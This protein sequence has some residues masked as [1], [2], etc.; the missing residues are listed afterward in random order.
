[1]TVPAQTECRC[2]SEFDGSTAPRT[3]ST[4][5]STGSTTSTTSSST[6]TSA[7]P[8]VP[9]GGTAAAQ[10]PQVLLHQPQVPADTVATA[11]QT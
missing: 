8:Q 4:S 1:M 10:Q 6:S 11:Q 3:G 2:F 9:A 5:S 7:S